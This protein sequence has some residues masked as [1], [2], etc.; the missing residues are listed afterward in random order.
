MI[1]FIFCEAQFSSSYRMSRFHCRF[2]QT[3]EMR[4]CR[5][6]LVDTRVLRM[7]EIPKMK[8]NHLCSCQRPLRVNIQIPKNKKHEINFHSKKTIVKFGGIKLEQQKRDA[9]NSNET[10]TEFVF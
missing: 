4:F 2:C 9:D 8:S 1:N 3:I 6:H 7:L 5:V 10:L